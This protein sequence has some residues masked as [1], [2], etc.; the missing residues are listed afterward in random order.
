M[1]SLPNLNELSAGYVDV[2]IQNDLFARAF[3][4]KGITVDWSKKKGHKPIYQT[5]SLGSNPNSCVSNVTF[6][7]KSSYDVS[8]ILTKTFRGDQT[9][10]R[11]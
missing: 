7:K 10:K 8:I 3:K 9:Y 4:E 11:G 2:D 6:P 1:G 5:R